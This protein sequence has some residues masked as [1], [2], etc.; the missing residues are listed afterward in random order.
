MADK[1]LREWRTEELESRLELSLGFSGAAEVAEA[2]RILR[3]RYAKPERR[4]LWWTLLF[5]AIAAIA[6]VIALFK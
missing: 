4:L 5:S 2:K 3:E 1:P 6:G